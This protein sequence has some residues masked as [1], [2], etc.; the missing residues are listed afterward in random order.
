MNWIDGAVFGFFLVSGFLFKKPRSIIDYGK[1]QAFKLLVPYFVY[2]MLYAVALAAIGKG[3]LLDGVLGMVT[4]RGAGMQLYFLPYLFLVTTSFALFF[5]VVDV[6]KNICPLLI[7]VG[8]LV[9][10]YANP[11]PSPTGSD[12]RLLPFYLGA[13]ALGL[14]WRLYYDKGKLAHFFVPA[15][16]ALFALGFSDQRFFDASGVLFLVSV[17]AL[18]F[19]KFPSFRLPGS[20]GVYL[21][22]TPLINFSISTILVWF[23]INQV[24]NIVASVLLTYAVC[25]VAVWVVR[26]FFREYSW[27]ILE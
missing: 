21:L 2:S 12:I 15:S 3:A 9:V 27:I 4:L 1:K 18:L 7:A 24:S 5:E 16:L 10:A 8:G 14:A 25:L 23:S 20:G 17:V 13:F 26:R 6:N 11:T 22:H 19:D